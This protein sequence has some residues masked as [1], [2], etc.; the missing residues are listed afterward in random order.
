M[1]IVLKFL[2]KNSTTNSSSFIPS[3]VIARFFTL[4][5]IGFVCTVCIEWL[6]EAAGSSRMGNALF[7]SFVVQINVHV[8]LPLNIAVVTDPTNHS[9]L[10]DNSRDTSTSGS[11]YLTIQPLLRIDIL[12]AT[13]PF[14]S[15]PLS[16]YVDF[17]LPELLKMVQEDLLGYCMLPCRKP[18]FWGLDLSGM[19]WLAMPSRWEDFVKMPF[20]RMFYWVSM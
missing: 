2:I 10:E 14:C 9:E 13:Y 11:S 5:V 17:T 1:C 15:P 16:F 7:C 18:M 3:H 6:T 19:L 12:L 4:C 20:Q 8:E